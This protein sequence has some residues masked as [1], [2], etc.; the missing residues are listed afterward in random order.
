MAAAPRV[1]VHPS[2]PGVTSL[3]TELGWLATSQDVKVD[4]LDAMLVKLLVVA[5]A[6]D[7]LKQTRLV[8]GRPAV[9]D[10][11]AAPIR[12]PRHQTIAFEQMADE[13]FG[14]R[15]FTQRGLE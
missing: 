11:D 9:G 8:D 15:W 12:L 14:H 5:K 1:D 4:A 3:H 6:H 2:S 7:V 13:G 10:A